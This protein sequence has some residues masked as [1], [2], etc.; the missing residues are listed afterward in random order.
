MFEPTLTKKIGDVRGK[1]A[2][3]KSQE[4]ER[5]GHDNPNALAEA[6]RICYVVHVQL[7]LDTIDRLIEER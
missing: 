5:L 2:Y 6:V 1:L 7:L 3:L 4:Y